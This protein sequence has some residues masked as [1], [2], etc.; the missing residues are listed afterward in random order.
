LAEVGSYGGYG[1]GLSVAGSGS[2]ILIDST[3]SDNTATRDGAGVFVEDGS[4]TIERSTI[5][6]NAAGNDWGG[7]S[8]TDGSALSPHLRS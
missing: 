5:S 3:V 6:E 4:I 7:I 1:G 2:A 8:N